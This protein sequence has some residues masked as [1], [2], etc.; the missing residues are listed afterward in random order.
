MYPDIICLLVLALHVTGARIFPDE[1][2]DLKS[3]KG[4][5]VGEKNL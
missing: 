5:K 4:G 3:S 1:T 2:E